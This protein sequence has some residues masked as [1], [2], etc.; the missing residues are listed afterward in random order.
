[1]CTDGAPA[2]PPAQPGASRPSRRRERGDDPLWIVGLVGRAGSGKSTVAHAFAERGFPV[3]EA[4]VLGHEVTE[5]DPEVRAALAADYGADVYRADGTLDRARVAARVFHDPT[6]LARLNALVHPRIVAALLGGL[7]A[8][9]VRGYRGVVIVEAALIL[10]WGFERDCDF[11]LAVTAPESDLIERLGR[12]RGWSEEDS[13]ARLN[14]QPTP[15]T[16][17]AAADVVI[18]NRGTEAELVEAA[19]REVAAHSPVPR[20]GAES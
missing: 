2:R 7:S 1:M 6:A 19:L 20:R 13:R 3:L 10:N 17:A 12:T 5:R 11:V 18:E 4:D 14:A 16:M 8:L 9:R 15:E